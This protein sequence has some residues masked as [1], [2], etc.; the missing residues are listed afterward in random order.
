[1]RMDSK[2]H[3][4]LVRNKDGRE[5]PEDEFIVF[6]PSDNACLQMLGYY[7]GLVGNQGASAE[8][9]Q[10]VDDLIIRVAAWRTAHPERC[11][12]ADVQPGELQT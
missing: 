3:G 5:I 11:K 10:A 1:M 12:V 9:L 2:V 6:R 4:T 7:R 8:Q